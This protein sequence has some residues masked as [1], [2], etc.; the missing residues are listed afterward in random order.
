[1]LKPLL[2]M[3]RRRSNHGSKYDQRFIGW[4]SLLKRLAV[5]AGL[6]ISLRSCRC[7]CKDVHPFLLPKDLSYKMVQE[8]RFRP[9][10]FGRRSS[11]IDLFHDHIPMFASG[12]CLEQVSL[13]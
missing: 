7:L 10:V 6:P 1:M 4:C 11:Y 13:G 9:H 8:M 2:S 5:L 12:I 3:V